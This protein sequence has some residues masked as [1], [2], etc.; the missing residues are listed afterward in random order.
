MSMGAMPRRGSAVPMCAS[1]LPLWR[2]PCK[3]RG[4]KDRRPMF[5]PMFK[6]ATMFRP[7]LPN[8]SRGAS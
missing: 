7:I 1:A 8:P 3:H 6:F 5:K 2:V 4:K